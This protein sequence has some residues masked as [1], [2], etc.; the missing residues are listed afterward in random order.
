[1]STRISLHDEHGQKHDIEKY[2]SSIVYSGAY[3]VGWNDED[4]KLVVETLSDK[5]DGM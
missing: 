1:M 2:I 4:K 5:A 3:V